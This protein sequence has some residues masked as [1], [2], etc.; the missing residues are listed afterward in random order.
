LS[1]R[2]LRRDNNLLTRP[3]RDNSDYAGK[4]ACR[5]L[6]WPKTRSKVNPNDGF[7]RRVSFVQEILRCLYILY[8]AKIDI[9]AH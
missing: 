5:E 4:R 7:C 2:S 6:K 3:F 9:P 1:S 8:H